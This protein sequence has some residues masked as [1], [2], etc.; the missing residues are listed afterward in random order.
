MTNL[1][2]TSLLMRTC[3]S[4][5]GWF[6]F[7]IFSRLPFSIIYEY[8]FGHLYNTKT[9]CSSLAGNSSHFRPTIQLA[10]PF[11][12]N[13]ECAN[14]QGHQRY[15]LLIF[16]FYKNN[17]NMHFVS[18]SRCKALGQKQILVT[19][20]GTSFEKCFRVFASEWV[21]YFYQLCARAMG[22]AVWCTCMHSFFIPFFEFFILNSLPVQWTFCDWKIHERKR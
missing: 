9:S 15:F 8:S 13:F 21:R 6:S 12:P 7:C 18:I 20:M 16:I 17:N 14:W 10:C 3:F 19:L 22:L 1:P 11:K 2:F 4:S 5:L